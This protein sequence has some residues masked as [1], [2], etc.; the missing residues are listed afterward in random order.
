MKKITF[1]T[2]ELKAKAVQEMET[3]MAYISLGDVRRAVETHAYAMVQDEMLVD[4]DVY[5]DEEDEHYSDM[6]D[7]YHDNLKRWEFKQKQLYIAERGGKSPQ[8]LLQIRKEK[9][10]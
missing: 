2:E 4:L 8:L 6:I 7:I 1:T 9:E 10:Q 3:C 5:L